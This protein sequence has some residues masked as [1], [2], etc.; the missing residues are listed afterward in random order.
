[1]KLMCQVKKWNISDI[2]KPCVHPLI[3]F[4]ISFLQRGALFLIL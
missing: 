1:M 4:F 3:F 2:L